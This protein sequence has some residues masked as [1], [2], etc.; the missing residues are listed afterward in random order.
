MKVLSTGN[1]DELY[2]VCKYSTDV[3]TIP[4]GN[5]LNIENFS[6]LLCCGKRGL[7]VLLCKVSGKYSINYGYLQI[8][9]RNTITACRN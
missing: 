6:E 1:Y 4:A 5:L 9:Y 7:P 8:D 2:F 3:I